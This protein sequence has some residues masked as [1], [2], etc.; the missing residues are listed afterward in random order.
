MEFLLKHID[1]LV[2]F[3]IFYAIIGPIG[4]LTYLFYDRPRNKKKTPKK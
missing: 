2:L 3:I 1:I 4:I